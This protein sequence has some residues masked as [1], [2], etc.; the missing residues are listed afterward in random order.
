MGTTVSAPCGC[1]GRLPGR[2]RPRIPPHTPPPS[3]TAPPAR[4]CA[5]CRLP[6]TPRTFPRCP[7]PA[8][9]A[10]QPAQPAPPHQ[11]SRA[12]A[13]VTKAAQA[14]ADST[15]C[16]GTMLRG[17]VAAEPSAFPRPLP[18]PPSRPRQPLRVHPRPA[19]HSP[20]ARAVAPRSSGG[21]AQQAEAPAQGEAGRFPRAA[22]RPPRA[23]A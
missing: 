18:G 17:G 13:L 7:P 8:A 10:C 22:A 15:V 16:W 14:L 3:R 6:R 1:G 20:A 4:P 19:F 5:A 11:A 21:A 2:F 12:L 9:A 23:A